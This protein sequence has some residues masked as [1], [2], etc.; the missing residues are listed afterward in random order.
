MLNPI[1]RMLVDAMLLAAMVG[2][3]IDGD[4][5]TVKRNVGGECPRTVYAERLEASPDVMQ[6]FDEAVRS[7]EERVRL[8][9][10]R[11]RPK[12]VIMMHIHMPKTGGMSIRKELSDHLGAHAY[13]SIPHNYTPNLANFLRKFRSGAPLVPSAFPV[14]TNVEHAHDRARDRLPLM[15][16]LLEDLL[17]MRENRTDECTIRL[18]AVLRSPATQVASAFHYDEKFRHGR[19]LDNFT[20]YMNRAKS[21][22]SIDHQLSFMLGRWEESKLCRGIVDTQPEPAFS[23]RWALRTLGRFDHIG[24]TEDL[25]STL[26]WIRGQFAP[27][28]PSGQVAPAVSQRG[29]SRPSGQF[30]NIGSYDTSLDGDE[31]RRLACQFSEHDA[32]LHRW[33]AQAAQHTLL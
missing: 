30:V 14:H 19:V 26:A 10:R 1:L 33:A 9:A 27:D 16:D 7:Y 18:F 23:L 15:P 5:A 6:T 28:A 21:C 12:C 2:A 29:T 22:R 32:F 25:D 8:N 4:E 20:D 13:F 31:S 11:G 3:N 24:V 17:R